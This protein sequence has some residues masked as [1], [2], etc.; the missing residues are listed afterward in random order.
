MRSLFKH[1]SCGGFAGLRN[2]QAT[3]KVLRGG[4]AFPAD[5]FAV[6][7]LGKR[8][9]EVLRKPYGNY[10]NRGCLATCYSTVSYDCC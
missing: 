8:M 6:G 10:S 5:A 2:S 4:Q 7:N 3:Y 9:L 1:P